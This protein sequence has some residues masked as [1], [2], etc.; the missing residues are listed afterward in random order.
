VEANQGLVADRDGLQQRI[1][2]LSRRLGLNSAN[3]SRTPSND[4]LKRTRMTACLPERERRKRLG[5]RPGKQ[6]G[7]PGCH[8]AQ[9][10]NPDEE[11]EMLPAIFTHCGGDLA[12]GRGGDREA[13]GGGPAA[14]AGT[15]DD[16][17]PSP[18]A[19]AVSTADG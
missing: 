4:G 7:T 8:L 18:S 15:G 2:E 12:R 11:V 1:E 6:R 10:A 5:R 19:C 16:R 17:V 3:S 14:A 9:M 13:A